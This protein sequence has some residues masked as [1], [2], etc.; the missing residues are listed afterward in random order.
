MEAGKLIQQLG[1]HKGILE[2][3]RLR[4]CQEEEVR[5]EKGSRLEGHEPSSS[6]ENLVFHG[7]ENVF[8]K[9]VQNLVVQEHQTVNIGNHPKCFR[10]S[11]RKTYYTTK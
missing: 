7:Q 9:L 3:L 11:Q 1:K 2:K 5:E 4:H 10:G 8:E 6:K